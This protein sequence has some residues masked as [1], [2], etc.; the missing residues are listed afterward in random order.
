MN[1]TS[2]IDFSGS[3][4][5]WQPEVW[6]RLHFSEGKI[7]SIHEDSQGVTEAWGMKA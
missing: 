3:G 6:L 7:H 4:N 1:M 2:G 5:S